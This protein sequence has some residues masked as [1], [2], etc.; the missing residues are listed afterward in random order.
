MR[1]R[2]RRGFTLIELLAALALT[3][4]AVLGGLL[5]LDQVADSGRRIAGEAAAAARDGNGDR[6]LRHLLLEA[7]ASSDT[8]RRLRGDTASVDLWTRCDDPGGWSEPCHVTIGI[9]VHADTSAVVAVYSSGQSF[10][11][12][13]TRGS[14]AFR[15]FNGPARDSS[16]R[17]EWMSN[18]TLPAAIGLL[19][20]SDTFV[21]PVGLHP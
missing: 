4:F 5:L 21:F 11:L 16:W 17:K 7:A 2:D 18:V 15:Y 10:V 19:V 8:T 6:M 3:G 14:A 1:S 9:D 12:R 20:V 13:R